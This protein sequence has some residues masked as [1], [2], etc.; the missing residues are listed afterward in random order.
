MNE[1]LAFLESLSSELRDEVLMSCS[2]EF[3]ES[4]PV[5]IQEESRVVRSRMNDR[6]AYNHQ[7]LVNM[8]EILGERVSGRLREGP[9][10]RV[11][12]NQVVKQDLLSIINSKDQI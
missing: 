3:L 1:N 7:E 8:I 12:V 10:Q 4:L 6:Y 9:D 2:L 5:E 11:S